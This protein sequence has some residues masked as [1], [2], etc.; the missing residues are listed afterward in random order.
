MF[1]LSLKWILPLWNPTLGFCLS[2]KTIFYKVNKAQKYN[3][4]K[5]KESKILFFEK[6]FMKTLLY[7]KQLLHFLVIYRNQITC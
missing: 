4:Q 6:I 7:A 1:L 3:T 2:S 5:I